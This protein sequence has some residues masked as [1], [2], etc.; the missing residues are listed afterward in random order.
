MAYWSNKKYKQQVD[1]SYT[2]VVHG[3]AVN[4]T[5]QDFKLLKRYNPSLFTNLENRIRDGLKQSCR[6]G[7]HILA[8]GG[9]ARDAVL[10][11]IRLLED[12]ELFNA[13]K[14]SC[15]DGHG[16]YRMDASIMDGTTRNWGSVAL[17]DSVRHPIDLA[18][19]CLNRGGL[20]LAGKSTTSLAKQT[21]TELVP[22]EYFAS[23]YR[24][25]LRNYLQ[26]H[27]INLA[28]GE[29]YLSTVGVVAM[30]QYG[31]ICAGTST[32]GIPFKQ[33]GRIGDTPMIGISTL[34]NSK[35]GGISC[36]GIGEYFV[37]ETFAHDI[38]SQME[39]LGKDL[40]EA[41]S[42]SLGKL[43]AQSGGVIG[44]DANG[45]PNIQYNTLAMFRGIVRSG[46][47]TSTS[48]WDN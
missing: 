38:H 33:S 6:S 2:L 14:G 30:D 47:D 5:K 43:P 23:E 32:G 37:R 15:Q 41:I 20:F 11:A 24:K 42:Y 12:N 40:D 22:N 18:N 39:Y 8:S 29:S 48:I 26:H 21:Q 1:K 7:E 36:S 45:N 25:Q 3:G 44:I 10:S 46:E 34:A 31:N 27:H 28:G 13:G 16:K 9:T 19:E 35:Y 4:L 17:V